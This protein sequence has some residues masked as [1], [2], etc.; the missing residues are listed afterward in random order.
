MVT[1]TS[2]AAIDP[3]QLGK[4]LEKEAAKIIDQDLLAGQGVISMTPTYIIEGIRFS[5]CDFKAKDLAQALSLA[6][7]ARKGDAEAKEEIIEMI[8]RGHLN[9]DIL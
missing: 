6:K 4:T 3:E 8:T 9:E 1:A 2:E 5:A 7:R